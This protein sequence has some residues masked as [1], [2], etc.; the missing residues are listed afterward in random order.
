MNLDRKRFEIHI[1]FISVF[2]FIINWDKCF[3]KTVQIV[4]ILGLFVDSIRL[5]FEKIELIKKSCGKLLESGTDHK[6]L[7]VFCDT[8]FSNRSN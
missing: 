4:E 3:K 5:S 8:D 7:F 2:V 1:F 6:K